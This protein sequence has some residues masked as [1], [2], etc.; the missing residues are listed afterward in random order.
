MIFIPHREKFEFSSPVFFSAHQDPKKRK[1]EKK[2][3]QLQK[4]PIPIQKREQRI[5]AIKAVACGLSADQ[6]LA[7]SY[8]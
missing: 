2:P 5:G 3:I 4:N 6:G 8:S 7:T 1:E